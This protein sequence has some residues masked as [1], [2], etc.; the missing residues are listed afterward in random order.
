M[1]YTELERIIIDLPFDEKKDIYSSNGQ[2][3]YVVR[4]QKLS[5]RFKEYDASK[6]IQIWLKINNK[7]PFKPNHFRLLIDLY[8]RVRECPD[9]KDT[10]LEVFDR[11]FY[12]E[13]PLNVMHMLDTYQF[14]Q[15]INPTDI[16]VVLAQLFIAEQN[17]GFGKKSKYNPRSLYIQGWIRTFINADYEIDQVISG[18]SYNR[19]PLVGYTKQDD[20]NHKEYNPDAQPLW[21]K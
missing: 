12:G 15:A 11:I 5:E 4:P 1:K 20:K 3:L 7:K 19:P 17:V 6:N 9:S 16:A 10:L 21:Y 8:T 13:D 2:T 18:I 14:T